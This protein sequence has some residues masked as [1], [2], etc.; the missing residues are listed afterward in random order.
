MLIEEPEGVLLSNF[1]PAGTTNRCDES[2][3]YNL[4]H[5]GPLAMTFV[6]VEP[7]QSVVAL[8]VVGRANLSSANIAVKPVLAC[9]AAPKIKYGLL[10]VTS[11]DP[12]VQRARHPQLGSHIRVTAAQS[13][14]IGK[15][16]Q[17][18]RIS[19]C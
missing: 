12:T 13:I 17:I 6:E 11:P 1:V 15:P 9:E 4:T 8:Y 18:S 3:S 5:D 16:R 7:K 14:W 19:L 2:V 10:K